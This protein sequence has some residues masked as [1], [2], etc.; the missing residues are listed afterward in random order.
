MKKK[1]KWQ[2]Y[3]EDHLFNDK[4]YNWVLTKAFDTAT[5]EE[6]LTLLLYQLKQFK[7]PGI[8][9]A[10]HSFIPEDIEIILH[11]ENM[12]IKFPRNHGL[13]P[14]FRCTFN[15]WEGFIYDRK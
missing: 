2:Q 1:K 10:P 15:N 13:Y 12:P 4:A 11:T 3:S 7:N 14:L 6:R 9:P 5:D 8:V